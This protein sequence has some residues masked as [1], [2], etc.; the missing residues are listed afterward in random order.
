MSIVW[1][2]LTGESPPDCGGVGDYTAELARALAAAGDVVH[3]WTPSPPSRSAAGVTV[4]TLPDHFGAASRRAMDEAWQETPG[5]ILLQYVGHALGARGANLA[6]CRWFSRL[7]ET[8]PDVR[9]MF[10]EPYMYF[11]WSRPWARSNVL[12]GVQRT[13]A[14][15]LL[16]GARGVYQSTDTWGRYLSAVG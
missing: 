7:R 6:F 15:A 2:L 9:V 8:Q 12:A 11:T 14:R 3:V 1:H 4:H 13:M 16:R 5:V 10:H